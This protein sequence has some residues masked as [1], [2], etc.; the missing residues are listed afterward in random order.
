MALARAEQ[1]L[2]GCY[3]APSS[4]HTQ[5]G[6]RICAAAAG[7]DLRA[8]CML[9]TCANHAQLAVACEQGA[10][11]AVPQADCISRENCSVAGTRWERR[12]AAWH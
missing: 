9:P 6:G 7:A 10:R 5:F 2:E 4:I 1:A 12:Q 11:V 3:P 8:L